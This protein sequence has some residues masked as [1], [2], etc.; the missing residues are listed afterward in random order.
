MIALTTTSFTVIPP[1]GSVHFALLYTYDF[2]HGILCYTAI[3]IRRGADGI[4]VNE[5]EGR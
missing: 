2:Y 3:I 1:L 4:A 5:V